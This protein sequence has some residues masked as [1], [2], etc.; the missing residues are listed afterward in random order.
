MFR[1]CAIPVLVAAAGLSL[2]GCAGDANP[3]RDLAVATG[4]TGG[5]PKPAPDFVTR[6]RAPDAGYMP[7]GVSAPRRRLRAKDATEV[8]GAEAEMNRLR[9]ANESR[10]AGARRAAS[11]P[12]PAPVK[13]PTQ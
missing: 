12:A 10:A 3:V 2:A 1:A 7:V 6:T 5:E 4:V 13:P 11:G 8:K 9:A